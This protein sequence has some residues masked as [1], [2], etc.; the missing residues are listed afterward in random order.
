MVC[1]FKVFFSCG[2]VYV[3]LFICS[4]RSHQQLAAGEATEAF[5]GGQKF[6]ALL[7]AGFTNLE[8]LA[9]TGN[10]GWPTLLNPRVG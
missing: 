1:L 2:F 8:R 10:A 5:H 6:T 9:D 4:D 3:A 7:A